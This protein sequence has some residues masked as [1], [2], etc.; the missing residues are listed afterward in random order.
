[1]LAVL[2]L[3]L[4]ATPVLAANHW[5]DISD[6]Q[7][8]NTY[9]ITADQAYNV[10]AGYPDGTFR[11][12]EAVTRAQC[13]KM[14]VDGTDVGTSTPAAPDF[15]D[16]RRRTTTIHGSRG[17]SPPHHLRL[18]R[19]HLPSS[20]LI[21]RQQFNSI[22]G[23]D[24]AQIEIAKRGSIQGSAGEYQSLAAWYAA[25]G[26][27]FLAGFS[28]GQAVATVHRPGTA[29]LVFKGVVHGATRG[30]LKYLDPTASLT[31]AQAVAMIVR[32]MVVAASSPRPQPS[33]STRP[34]ARRSDS[35]SP[36]NFTVVFSKDVTGFTGSDVTL[37]GTAGATT[38]VVTG[39]G[40]TYNVAVSGMT[41]S[42]T[43]IASIRGGDP[44]C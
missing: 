28:D 15:S 21:T 34:A 41:Q 24:L 38:A 9:Q 25:E 8:V 26:Q 39:S 33:P 43:V 22:L 18:R 1:V 14:I 2:L 12:G 37:S 19:W 5:S 32:A 23:L 36:I 6:S 44:R 40:R 17:V 3:L 4:M 20:N 11:P 30:G 35:V 42:G 10:A 29:Y 7:W 16:V 31:R 13:A 27:A